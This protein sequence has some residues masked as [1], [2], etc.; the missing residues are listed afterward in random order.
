[1]VYSFRYLVTKGTKVVFDI[2]VL[3]G[4]ESWAFKASQFIADMGEN[5]CFGGE[6]VMD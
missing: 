5:L 1:M 6:S 4:P 2:W 3:G